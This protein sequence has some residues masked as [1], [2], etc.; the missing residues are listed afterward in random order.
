MY[1]FILKSIRFLK[2]FFSNRPTICLLW[3][4]DK[5]CANWRNYICA[6]TSISRT[7]GLWRKHAN[8]RTLVTASEP[9]DIGDSMWTI[10][11]WWQQ[12]NYRTLVCQTI[13]FGADHRHLPWPPYFR[14]LHTLIITSRQYMYIEYL[15][16]TKTFK[17]YYNKSKFNKNFP[18]NFCCF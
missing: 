17:N 11:L 9:L 8:H 6:Y 5:T 7:I 13:G 12:A 14:V 16:M 2:A 1:L 10:G 15:D 3:R 4:I 18:L